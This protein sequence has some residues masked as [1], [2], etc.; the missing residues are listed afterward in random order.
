MNAQNRSNAGPVADEMATVGATRLASRLGRWDDGQAPLAVNLAASIAA[1]VRSG[2]LRPGDRLPPERA[3]AAAVSVSRGTVVAAFGS[4]AEQGIVERRQGSGTRVSGAP[5]ARPERA[6]QG[7]SLFLAAP[8]SINLLRAVPR[9]PERAAQIVAGFE[10]E[11]ALGVERGDL[12]AERDL[13]VDDLEGSAEPTGLRS[14]RERIAARLGD[15]GTPTTA[16]QIIV[17]HGAQQ[18]LSLVID[19]LVEPGDVVLAEAV[20]WPG[21]VDP[22]RRRGGR[23]YGIP[24]TSEGIDLDALESAIVALRPVLVAVNPHHHNPTGTR[25]PAPARAA[26][27]AMA[28]RYGIPVIEDRV[29]AHI[30]FDGVVPPTL[31]SLRPDAPIIV[32]DSLSKWA[33]PGLRI[34]WARA[35]PVLVRRLRITRQLVDQ[36]ASVPAQLL[37]EGLLDEAPRLRRDVSLAHAPRAALL[38]ELLGEHLPGWRAERPLGGLAMWAQ[39]PTGS[40]TEFARRAAMGG[41]AVAGGSE[42]AAAPSTDDHL[43]LPFTATEAQLREGL[44]R[45]GELWAAYLAGR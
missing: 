33:W 14:L 39:L 35:D 23:V 27:A 40:A 26:L 4:L 41:V 30:S 32:V 7:A 8:K 37:A 9:M 43:R 6:A 42:F 2:E 20:T 15:E 3:L 18:A 10:L 44:A 5:T 29:L 38:H 1:L 45:L 36:H 22:V 17:T 13:G 31:A 21:L 28:A 25:M 19:E 12:G 16:E 34:G 11:R 24:M